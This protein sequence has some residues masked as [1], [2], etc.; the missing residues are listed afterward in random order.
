VIIASGKV[1]AD[2]TPRDLVGARDDGRA[3]QIRIGSPEEASVI[4]KIRPLADGA[5]LEVMER[6]NGS[7]RVLL[8]YRDVPEDT[9]AIET[10]LK[11]AN[12]PV[13]EVGVYRPRLEDV[14]RDVTTRIH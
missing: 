5:E 13:E 10:R 4:E 7:T 2:A 9:R 1:V 6:M 11:S 12:L 8:R 14:F 3:I